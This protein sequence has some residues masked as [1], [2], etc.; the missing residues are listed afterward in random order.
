MLAVSRDASLDGS[1]LNPNDRVN[2]FRSAHPGGANFLWGDG[3][4]RFISNSVDE[5][6]YSYLGTIRGGELDRDDEF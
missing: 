6:I 5:R 1:C 2:E 4:V 3:T